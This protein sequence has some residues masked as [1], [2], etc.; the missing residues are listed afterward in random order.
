MNLQDVQFEQIALRDAEMHQLRSSLLNEQTQT[1]LL[2]GLRYIGKT[3]LLHAF[4]QELDGSDR[5]I[6]AYFDLAEN[7]NC[8]AKQLQSDLATSII[9]AINGRVSDKTN[10]EQRTY[11]MKHIEL[12]LA[13]LQ[14]DAKVLIAVDELN[15]LGLNAFGNVFVDGRTSAF[16]E[17]LAALGRTER[18]KFVVVTD[19]VEPAQ[20]VDTLSPS[21]GDIQLQQ[22]S[23]L[24]RVSAVQLIRNA[25]NAVLDWSDDGVVEYLWAI[26]HGHPHLVHQVTSSIHRSVQAAYS[27]NKARVAVTLS[28]V[29]N[30][31]TDCIEPTAD[32][33][34]WVWEHL[35][36]EAQTIASAIAGFGP[37]QVLIND[38]RV[39][40]TNARVKNATAELANANLKQA[41]SYLQ[42]W[43]LVDCTELDCRFNVEFFRRWIAKHHPLIGQATVSSHLRN[44]SATN[45]AQ[46]AA[47]KPYESSSQ[48]DKDGPAVEQTPAK[49]AAA[50]DYTTEDRIKNVVEDDSYAQTNVG[51]SASLRQLIVAAVALLVI[52]AAI[53]VPSY[54]GTG[55]TRERSA[56]LPTAT[57]TTSAT[58]LEATATSVDTAVATASVDV[59]Y[60]YTLLN[61]IPN[62]DQV[63][64][65]RFSPDGTR[66]AAG[67]ANGT[68]AIW[69]LSDT[70]R[71]EQILV[72]HSS[73]VT[74]LAFDPQNPQR[75]ISGSTDH[76]IR[77]W[78]I[79]ATTE[80]LVLD[81]HTDQ[82]SSVA[83]LPDGTAFASASAD[84]TIRLW[85]IETG[86]LLNTL[87]SNG[88]AILSIDISPSGL[89]LAS[90]S[91]DGKSIIWN[92]ETGQSE[93]E[94]PEPS[95][96]ITA[97]AFLAGDSQ[98]VTGS[99]TGIAQLW[100]LNSDAGDSVAV[101]LQFNV[102]VNSIAVAPNGRFLASAT[103]AN[104]VQ[105]W[106]QETQSILPPLSDHAAV[107]RSIAYSPNGDYFVSGAEDGMLRRWQ[108]VQGRE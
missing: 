66:M 34:L 88:S 76:T 5:Y 94:L 60:A 105:I 16:L 51:K 82:I 75:L 63:W 47:H 90:G 57:G 18:V 65:V 42:V 32:A 55:L 68:I 14:S 29:G 108:I 7:P 107:V 40:L 103:D 59:G 33:P 19:G 44:A 64:S 4:T 43:H 97:I 25:Y 79:G 101:E 70:S 99:A 26:T 93:R 74:T 71:I 96:P 62:S 45:F 50:A 22:I 37:G 39:E 86:E 83:T 11:G 31:L 85:N 78:Q 21:L 27:D 61:E 73:T 80:L 72:G 15:V 102:A 10:D 36:S 1:I 13:S 89:W 100:N 6:P 98:V 69:N 81:A 28:M 95:G 17:F 41:L 67:L 3:S 87:S 49:P 48:A 91:A 20:L 54:F 58:F 56:A 35:P 2:Y 106:D 52:L 46:N 77:T 9:D 104:A 84:G 23:L 53:F 38:L 92:L 24:D 30:A 12:A 8:S